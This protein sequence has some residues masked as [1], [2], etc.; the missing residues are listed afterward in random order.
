MIVIMPGGFH[1]FHAG[2][3]ALY[4]SAKKTF[5]GAD[6]YV[7]A[8]NDMSERPF[9]FALKEKLAKLAGVEP[10]HFIQVKSPFKA[11]E[12]TKNYD[13]NKDVLV[14]V[15]SEKDRNEQPKPG[16][17]KKDG[18]PAYFQ[19]WTGKDLK[20]FSQH[21]YMA[22][23]PTVEFGPGI[24]SATQIRK[25]W[26]TLNDKR[27]T[28]LVMSLYPAAQKNPKLAQTV[29]QMF[30]QVMGGQVSEGAPIVV[31]PSPAR[32]KKPEQPKQRYMGDIV[33]P[34][35]PPSTEKRGVKGR[36]GQRP[37]PKLD[38]GLGDYI[39]KKIDDF[40][41]MPKIPSHEISRLMKSAPANLP[42][43]VAEKLVAKF[44]ETEKA[45]RLAQQAAEAN[46]TTVEKIIPYLTFF[47]DKFVEGWKRIP[48]RDRDNAL[49]N[50]V[51]NIG[52][53]FLFILEALIKGAT[54]KESIQ[55]KKEKDELFIGA[56]PESEELLR[57]AQQHYPSAPTKQQA[58]IK[59]VQRALK[60]SEEEDKEQDNE[61]EQLNKDVAQI[62][63][64]VNK[65]QV[66]ESQDYIEEK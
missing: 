24:T 52:R 66:S 6:L 21:A 45:K 51:Y 7:A 29:V 31:M 56:D 25:A 30:D 17:T 48:Q 59:F 54:K 32:L 50:L 46:K 40:L 43:D 44:M 62:K 38:E 13:P 23:L 1:P 36:P 9:P 34:S 26:P 58:F 18:S 33:P 41:D 57:Y 61:I 11:E 42:D 27:K 39:T 4:Q 47:A 12:I 20:P 55:E 64:V 53:F 28:A 37:M 10:G 63:Q 8:T 3:Y 35:Q 16:G 5:P 22:Y 60:H 14:F 15:R 49:K 2:H 65:I 19:P